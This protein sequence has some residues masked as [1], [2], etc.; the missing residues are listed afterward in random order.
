[1]ASS[2]K[3]GSADFTYQ[4]SGLALQTHLLAVPLLIRPAHGTRVETLASYYEA[5]NDDRTIRESFIIGD[6]VEQF[7]GII[8]FDDE[9]TS[10]RSMLRYGRL[11][12]VTLNYRPD[13]ASGSSYPLKVVNVGGAEG[14]R[15]PI[16]PDRDRFLHA[17]WEASVLFR[18]VDGG[19]LDGLLT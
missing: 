11:E 10:L 19:S 18:R 15:V 6:E 16:I 8:R 2:Q 9:P 5:W 14:G 3:I 13:G 7:F 17:E 12:N 1:M 4:P